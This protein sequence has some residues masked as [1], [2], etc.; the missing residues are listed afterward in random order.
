MHADDIVVV[1]AAIAAIG[2][3]N[4]YFFVAANRR[5]DERERGQRGR[6]TRS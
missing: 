3:V 2:W 4:W 1:I 6:S 5:A